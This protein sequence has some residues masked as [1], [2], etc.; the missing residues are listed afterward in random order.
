MRNLPE[1]VVAF[2]S[3]IAVGGVAVPLN[4]W[5]TGDELAYGISDSGAAAL[6]CD[7]ERLA[8]LAPHLAGATA[9]APDRRRRERRGAS[10]LEVLAR[11]PGHLHLRD[12]E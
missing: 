5:W 12:R 10:R 1:W 3:A 4:A 8:R 7:P 9:L 6:F 2:W 11:E